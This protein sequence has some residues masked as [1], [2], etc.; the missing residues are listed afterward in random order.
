MNNVEKLRRESRARIHH[1]TLHRVEYV[2]PTQ[3]RLTCTECGFSE[4]QEVGGCKFTMDADIAKKLAHYR[5]KR[6]DGTD[7]G[8]MAECRKCTK[9]ARD[10]RYPRGW[11]PWDNTKAQS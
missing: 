2:P 6:S 8:I 11:S 5:G 7:G 9:A 3:E 10:R 4:V 1:R